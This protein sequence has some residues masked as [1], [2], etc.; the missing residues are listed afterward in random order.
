MAEWQELHL[1]IL[2]AAERMDS[3][4]PPLERAHDEQQMEKMKFE[5]FDLD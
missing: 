1:V 4:G 5:K 3:S 2:H